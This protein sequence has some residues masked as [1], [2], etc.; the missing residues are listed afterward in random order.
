MFLLSIHETHVEE[1]DAFALGA[2]DALF[3]QMY[4]VAML[5]RD[6]SSGEKSIAE[7]K[8]M[9]VLE[10]AEKEKKDIIDEKA[11]WN[12]YRVYLIYSTI[13]VGGRYGYPCYVLENHN[14]TRKATLEEIRRIWKDWSE[15]KKTINRIVNDVEQEDSTIFVGSVWELKDAYIAYPVWKDDGEFLH[16]EAW[17]VSKRDRKIER[18]TGNEEFT[19]EAVLIWA[20]KSNELEHSSYLRSRG[21]WREFTV[22]ETAVE[23]MKKLK[24]VCHDSDFIAGVLEFAD[25]EE[26]Q[27]ELLE[28]I[29]EKYNVDAEAVSDFAIEL[30]CRRIE[31]RIERGFL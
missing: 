8:M 15:R 25:N 7:G 16:D 5:N 11:P 17:L 30:S 26:D 2:L 24:K 13:M 19:D 31:K 20:R 21:C 10:I 1:S 22:S 3:D 12:G 14:G 23:L 18:I 6:R 9:T 27:Q 4:M 29:G 28:F